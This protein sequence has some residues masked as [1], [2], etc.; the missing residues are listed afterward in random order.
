MSDDGDGPA[1]DPPTAGS[2]DVPPVGASEEGPGPTATSRGSARPVVLLVVGLVVLV[3]VG[4]GVRLLAR[5]DES[6][7]VTGAEAADQ[8]VAAYTR[9]LDATYR[10]EGEFTRTAT[11]GRTLSSAYLAVQRPPDRLQRS[12]GSTS[13][14]V[15]GRTINCSTPTGGTYSCGA[16]GEATPWEEERAEVLGA[17]DQ[18]VRG[19]D[20]V[21]A[22]TAD[23]SG[24]FDLVRRRTE[25]DA[26]FGRRARICFDE[27]HGGYK[28]LEVEHDGG[29]V[30]VMLATRIVGDVTAADFDLDADATYD[31]VAPD[32]PGAV[33]PTT[34]Q[35]PPS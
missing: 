31:P 5:D 13:G 29:V 17:L 28:R 26:S 3:A 30:D 27:T 33:T 16:A 1:G 20:P 11:D 8:F 22:V 12:L 24:C 32:D 19:D 34:S 6:A 7:P 9:N 15:N 23:G 21:Y 4:V 14:V 18:Y 35:E 10:I 2:P 25:Q